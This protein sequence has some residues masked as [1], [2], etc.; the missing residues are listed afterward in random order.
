[1]TLQEQADA[2]TKRF[3]ERVDSGFFKRRPVVS[4]EADSREERDLAAAEAFAESDLF[5]ELWNRR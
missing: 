3:H 4:P 5:Q 1:M 2:A